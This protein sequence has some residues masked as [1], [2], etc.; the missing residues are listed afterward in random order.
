[1]K[2]GIDEDHDRYQTILNFHIRFLQILCKIMHKAGASVEY[3]SEG[4]QQE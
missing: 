4:S 3:D 1:M 2:E